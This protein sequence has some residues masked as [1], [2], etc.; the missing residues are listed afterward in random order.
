[1]LNQP[2]HPPTLS[3]DGRPLAPVANPGQ[4]GETLTTV[5]IVW[6]ES[7]VPTSAPL[8]GYTVVI[9]PIEGNSLPYEVETVDNK[10]EIELFQLTPG[11]NYSV[12]VFGRNS[13]GNGTASISVRISTVKPVAPHTPQEVEAVLVKHDTS[14]SINV[15]WTVR[16]SIIHVHVILWLL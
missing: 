9:A 15:S 10:T 14:F 2:I 6:G 5:T 13:N 4:M 16:S 12:Q 3:T 11:H 1:M 7:P 8:Q